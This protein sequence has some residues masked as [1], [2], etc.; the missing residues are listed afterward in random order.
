MQMYR[1]NQDWEKEFVSE[2]ENGTMTLTLYKPMD[3]RETNDVFGKVLIESELPFEANQDL[4][5]T[6]EFGERDHFSKVRRRRYTFFG[7]PDDGNFTIFTIAT[8][9]ATKENLTDYRWWTS[10]PQMNDTW[11]YDFFEYPASFGVD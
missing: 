4:R 6:L 2:T 9:K 3:T 10:I 5:L 11:R 8:E 1:I 7:D